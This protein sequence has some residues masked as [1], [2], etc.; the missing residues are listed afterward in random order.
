MLC[1]FAAF[2]ERNNLPR[3]S[4]AEMAWRVGDPCGA[5]TNL[6]ASTCGHPYKSC[7]ANNGPPITVNAPNITI[8]GTSLTFPFNGTI[9][10]IQIGTCPAGSME[11]TACATRQMEQAVSAPGNRENHPTNP[12]PAC[13]GTYTTRQC[14]TKKGLFGTLPPPLN[15]MQLDA[16]CELMPNVNPVPNNP[17][18]NNYQVMQSCLPAPAPQPTE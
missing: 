6:V 16:G 17:C 11:R 1:V 15:T 7:Q 12:F 13:G 18:P 4:D 10:T 3:L 5:T 14:R 8:P 9:Y 2:G